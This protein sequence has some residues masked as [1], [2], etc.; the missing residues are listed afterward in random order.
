MFKNGKNFHPDRLLLID[1]GTRFCLE[2]I[3]FDAGE[4]LE[5]LFTLCKADIT[6]KTLQNKKNS[7]KILNM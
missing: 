2:K 7:R 6:T 4:D 1:D 5:D 3:V